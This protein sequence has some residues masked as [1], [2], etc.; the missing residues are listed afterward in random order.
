MDLTLLSHEISLLN[1]RDFSNNIFLSLRAECVSDLSEY[2]SLSNKIKDNEV[3]LISSKT[4]LIK[5]ENDFNCLV[6]K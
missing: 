3:I 1:S 2:F 5:S 6:K 4:L